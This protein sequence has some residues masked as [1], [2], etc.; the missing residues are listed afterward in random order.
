MPIG[1]VGLNGGGAQ[2]R[3][4]IC[5]CEEKKRKGDFGPYLRLR[6]CVVKWPPPPSR[7]KQIFVMRGGDRYKSFYSTIIFD[8]I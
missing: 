8:K 5:L 7:G 4:A 3:K 6:S 2:L 1:G